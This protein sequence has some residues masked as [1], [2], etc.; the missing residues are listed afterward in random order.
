MATFQIPSVPTMGG[1]GRMEQVR[2][3]MRTVLQREP[4]DMELAANDPAY[5]SGMGAS[6]VDTNAPYSGAPTGATPTVASAAGGPP[7]VRRA[8]ARVADPNDPIIRGGVSRTPGG[9][10]DTPPPAGTPG[11]P[12]SGGGGTTSP[13]GTTPYTNRGSGT[14]YAGWNYTGFDFNQDANNRL[15]GKSA[16]YTLAQ[17]T[18]EAAEA[19]V[20]DIW[21]TRSGAEYFATNYL[22]PRLEE[23]GFEVL[24]I[25]G[26][27]MRIRDYNDRA[28]GHPGRWVD[29]VVN[30]DGEEHGLTP[31]IAW[32][33]EEERA[34]FGPDH[35]STAPKYSGSTGVDPFTPRDYNPDGTPKTSAAAA[36]AA[37]TVDERAYR[38]LARREARLGRLGRRGEV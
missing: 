14:G 7:V 10:T 31:A 37:A 38:Q 17:A 24:E 19:G 3:R 1:L 4:T 34:A 21:K 12:G 26:D 13:Y 29:W 32:Q 22:K 25:V 33:V 8:P 15:I 18:K 27:K 30:A 28:S 20:G 35:D 36:P 5:T 16:K 23:N 6:A 2:A 9:Q 11:S